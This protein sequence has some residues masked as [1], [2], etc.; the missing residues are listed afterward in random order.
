ME[1]TLKPLIT[2]TLGTY[3]Q[4]KFIVDALKGAVTQ[5]YENLEII[6]SDDCSQ[7]RTFDLIQ[8]FVSNYKGPHRIIVNRNEVNLGL[9]G[10]LNKILSLA[11][12]E[13]IVLSAG[14]DISFA[15]RSRISYETIIKAGVSSVS[16]SYIKIDGEGNVI[17]SQPDT[18]NQEIQKYD[19]EDYLHDCYKSGGCARVI[20]R[21]IIDEFGLLND[22][23]LTEDTTFNLRAFLLGGIAKC[24]M[25]LVYYRI[26]GKNVSKGANYYEYVKPQLIYNQYLKDTNTALQ[27]GLISEDTYNKVKKKIDDYLLRETALQTMYHK[28][29][30][31]KRIGFLGQAVFSKEYDSAL[32]KLLFKRFLSWS[33]NGF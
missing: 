24:G 19:I 2:F 15:E 30:I 20:S 23:C 14:D 11:H 22:D 25:P 17:D 33:K 4:E 13:Y 31:V 21:K 10:H 8:N 7:D 12:G 5:D 1:Q 29:G 28:Q 27:K 6:V 18:S 3:N 16:F 26:H 32:I 9:V